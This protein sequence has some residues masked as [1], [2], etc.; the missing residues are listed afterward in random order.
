[1]S[2]PRSQRVCLYL[3]LLH[4]LSSS[5]AHATNHQVFLPQR[6]MD[7]LWLLQVLLMFVGEGEGGGCCWP[8]T[9]R[10]V[11]ADLSAVC[12]L[13]FQTFPGIS[14]SIWLLRRV[15][16]SPGSSQRAATPTASR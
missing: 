6:Q 12:L 2:P 8:G 14:P 15:F 7:E 5:P 16:F 11:A 10:W 4:P 1:M 13:S 3:R 9:K